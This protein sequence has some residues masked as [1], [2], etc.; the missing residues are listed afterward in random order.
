MFC[1]PVILCLLHCTRIIETIRVAEGR[2][3]ASPALNYDDA[4]S[5]TQ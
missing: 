3:L 1:R 4:H 2:M 5:C